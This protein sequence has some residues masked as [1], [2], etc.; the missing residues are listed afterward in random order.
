MP[1]SDG[2]Y[3]DG[4]YEASRDRGTWSSGTIYNRRDIVEGSDGNLYELR[5]AFWG[6]VSQAIFDAAVADD[7]SLNRGAWNSG[8]NYL[9]DEFVTRGG[10][11]YRALKDNTVRTRDRRQDPAA[12]SGISDDQYDDLIAHGSI[13]RGTWNSGTSY[14]VG[15]IVELN[16]VK[17]VARKAGSGDDPSV[18]GRISDDPLETENGS[19]SGQADGS[20]SGQ[21]SENGYRGIIDGV[22]DDGETDPLST[23]SRAPRPVPRPESTPTRR[24]ARNG[25]CTCRPGDRRY[26]GVDRKRRHH[27]HLRRAMSR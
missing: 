25:Q 9:E 13:D 20:A 14:I 6:E 11:I 22:A 5:G 23:R 12:W 3:D 19:A 4:T 8:T 16:G 7:P 27:R 1:S 18:W 21:D 24:V 15:D 26:F 10:K 2:R 17:Y